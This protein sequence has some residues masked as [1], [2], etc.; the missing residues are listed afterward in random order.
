MMSEETPRPKTVQPLDPGN[1]SPETVK[2]VDHAP[3]ECPDVLLMSATYG[4]D[5]WVN[6]ALVRGLMDAYVDAERKIGTLEGTKPRFAVAHGRIL[7][8]M[9]S[10]EHRPDE[11]QLP[12][13]ALYPSVRGKD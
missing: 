9:D 2:S 6:G 4:A 7:A 11:K 5:S 8:A 12:Q 3:F 10:D 1:P 13:G